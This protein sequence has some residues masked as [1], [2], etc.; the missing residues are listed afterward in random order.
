LIGITVKICH[1]VETKVVRN[2]SGYSKERLLDLMSK[3]NWDI[4]C[5][6]VQDFNNELEQ[7]IMS[8]LEFLIPF[9]EIKVWKDNYSEPFWLSDMKRKRKNLFKNARRRESTRLFERCKKMD[10][11]I[12]KG[13]Q[14]SN[15]KKICSKILQGGQSGLWDAVK[16][17]Q[18]KPQKQIPT[19]M[20]YNGQELKTDESMAQGFADF[21]KQKVEDITMSTTV[22]QD[23]FNGEKKVDAESENFF[24]EERV[25]EVMKTLKDKSYYGSDNIPVKVLKDANKFW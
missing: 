3:E 11:K 12:R 4:D 2:W 22:K 19:K 9:K 24:T 14:K 8:V 5:Y 21:F 16:M 23:V 1:K 6:K 20:L 15:K 25:K 18:S 7:K 10:Q 13:E 17:A